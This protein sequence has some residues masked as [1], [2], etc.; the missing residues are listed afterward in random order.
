MPDSVKARLF[1]PFFTT[2]PVGEG[3]GLGL[4][5]VYGV[6]QRAGGMID[7]ASAPGEG[8]TFTLWLPST[9]TTGTLA[10]P[11]VPDAPPTAPVPGVAPMALVVDDEA[12][13]RAI[14]VRVLR[15]AGYV[16][17]EAAS[18]DEALAL[19]ATHAGCIGVLVTDFAMPGMTG[20]ML[21]E[22]A[23]AQ[24]PHLATVLVSGYTSDDATRQ[25]LQRSR[26]RF[27]AKPFTPTTLLATVRAALGDDVGAVAT[28][29]G[30][31]P[32]P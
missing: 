25:A 21:L 26:T 24:W 8:T 7:V 23:L 19:L 9:T 22:R 10:S 28:A 15:R 13:V 3:T 32:H 5:T 20:R 1:E 18:G 31:E 27:L 11:A 16:V 6:V 4:A 14:M 29:S 12:M 2:K 30:S 17:H